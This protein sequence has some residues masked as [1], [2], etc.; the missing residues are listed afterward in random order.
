VRFVPYTELDG[1]PNVIIDGAGTVD[2]LLTLSH[3]PG[4]SV[5]APLRADLSAEIAVKYLEQPEQHVEA[6]L[7]SNNHF[8]EDGLL[9]LFALV[10][11]ETALGLRDLVVDVARAGDFA[12]SDTRHAARVAFAISSLVDPAASPLDPAVFADDYPEMAARLYRELLPRVSEL[13]IDIDRFRDLWADEDEHLAASNAAFERDEVSIVEHRDLDLA[14]V[15]LPSMD[16]HVVHRFTQRRHAGVHPMSVHNRTDMMRIAYVREHDYSVELRY[17][18]VV[19][20]VSRPLMPRPDLALL[21]D[22]L[23]EVEASGGKWNFDG[24]G[25]LTPQLRLVDAEA[26]SLAPAAFINE[27]IAFLPDAAPAW[28]PWTETGF[29]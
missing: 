28:D 24:V 7:V 9:G 19:Q 20:F 16:A 14:V 25:G 23:N 12:R 27:L 29:R 2:T 10:D 1:Q 22:R 17:E 3:W 18:T 8:D 5:P 26:S 15:T 4:S 11:P 13:L 6:E 21:A